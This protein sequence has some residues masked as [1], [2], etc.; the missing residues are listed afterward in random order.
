ME[1]FRALNY[2][3]A[4]GSSIYAYWRA[5]ELACQGPPKSCPK[6][7]CAS[8]SSI[9]RLVR[10]HG[11]QEVPDDNV[12]ADD[13]AAT[14]HQAHRIKHR[15]CPIGIRGTLRWRNPCEAGFRGAPGS[16]AGNLMARA[17]V[18]T[19]RER[20]A[21]PTR[22]GLARA[23][24]RR[25][26][27]STSQLVSRRCGDWVCSNP[28]P[29][30]RRRRTT[31]SAGVE[32]YVRAS[33]P[34]ADL[35][36]SPADR[37]GLREGCAVLAGPEQ[38]ARLPT[39]LGSGHA[40]THGAGDRSSKGGSPP[41]G[42]HE[43]ARLTDCTRDGDLRTSFDRVPFP[44]RRMTAAPSR[45]RNGNPRGSRAG[46]PNRPCRS[47]TIRHAER[48]MRR[49][50]HHRAVR[51]SQPHQRGREVKCGHRA[52]ARGH[53]P[54]RGAKCSESYLP[55][56]D[57][58]LRD[59]DWTP[60]NRDRVPSGQGSLPHG[61]VRSWVARRLPGRQKLLAIQSENRGRRGV[62]LG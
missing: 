9:V 59:P 43:N 13:P 26:G 51:T 42:R 31:Q 37:S 38:E 4:V 55:R 49:Q 24:Q 61:P 29:P 39:R 28:S 36:A 3:S 25:S 32:R 40:V 14:R 33:L 2:H 1:A 23:Q 34:E 54:P 41:G 44:M 48:G 7:T 5:R 18:P 15:V 30:P 53:C 17:R 52:A 12:D 11:R 27:P 10:G 58:L 21:G 47:R 62:C 6:G 50:C 45:R 19:A 20:A 16:G 46:S 8:I 56:A 57:R 35:P 22:G 60:G